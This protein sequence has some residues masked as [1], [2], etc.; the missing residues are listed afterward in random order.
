LNL[1][2]KGREGNITIRAR[3]SGHA[4]WDISFSMKES[5]ASSSAN[6]GFSVEEDD[7]DLF[8]SSDHFQHSGNEERLTAN[9]VAGVLWRRLLED[10]GVEYA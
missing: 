2:K 5:D 4:I 6:G 1:R 9:D 3:A 7:F 10:A 8:F